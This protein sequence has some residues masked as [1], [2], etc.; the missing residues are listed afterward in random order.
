MNKQYEP[1]NTKSEY[2]GWVGV[3]VRCREIKTGMTVTIEW[4]LLNYK[5]GTYRSI[6][7][8][9]GKSF[10]V[11]CKNIKKE[12]QDWEYE[13]ALE[14]L[15]KLEPI[16]KALRHIG[17]MTLQYHLATKAVPI[18]DYPWLDKLIDDQYVEYEPDW[19]DT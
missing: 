15:E 7:I 4:Y 9:R 13:L 1:K 16:E 6:N 3:R 14:A 10:S 12:S 17:K 5:N 18:H 11:L 19:Q 8:K 2:R